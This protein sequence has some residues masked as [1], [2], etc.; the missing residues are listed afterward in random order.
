MQVYQQFAI[1][2][3]YSKEPCASNYVSKTLNYRSHD[4][5]RVQWREYMC[6]LI[7]LKNKSDGVS[8]WNEGLV[9]IWTTPMN[10]KT[11]QKPLDGKNIQVQHLVRRVA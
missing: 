8:F 9:P 5:Q 6:G 7:K 3:M 10:V 4:R 2:K 1:Q 11:N